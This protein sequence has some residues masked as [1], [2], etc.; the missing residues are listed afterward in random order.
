MNPPLD[1]LRHFASSGASGRPAA[2]W[3]ALLALLGNV[4][5]PAAV[6]IGFSLA[7]PGRDLL[8]ARLCAASPGGVSGKAKPGLL[9]P[10]CPLCTIA[11]APLPRP[12]DFAIPAQL[13]E[14]RQFRLRAAVSI[15]LVRHGGMQARAP[16]STA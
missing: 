11:A 8:E 2:I 12:P 3:L 1:K 15:A 7:E 6:S 14:Q 4:M 16:P 5:L 10:H 13:A 9:A